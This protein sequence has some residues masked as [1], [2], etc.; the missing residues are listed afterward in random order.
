MSIYLNF[1]SK[2]DGFLKD[3][4]AELVLK[5]AC[6]AGIGYLIGNTF[7]ILNPL[8][9]ALFCATT[10]LVSKVAD[11]LMKEFGFSNHENL[12]LRHTLYFANR[13]LCVVASSAIMVFAG[14]HIA[15]PT[16]VILWLSSAIAYE[17]LKAL[18]KK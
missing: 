18:R 11:K 3:P 15:F 6:S 16:G 2:D 14:S 4:T 9:S 13:S 10:V 7:S 17:A 8:H 12:E 5:A 1:S